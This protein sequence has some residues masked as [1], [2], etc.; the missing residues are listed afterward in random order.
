MRDRHLYIRHKLEM[1]FRKLS[2]TDWRKK[3]INELGPNLRSV[4]AG[5]ERKFRKLEAR[6][7]YAKAQ[8][9]SVE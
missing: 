4:V 9:Q 5:S 2:K 7:A 6:M 8:A 3:E 1:A